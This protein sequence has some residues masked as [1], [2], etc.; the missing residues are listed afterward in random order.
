MD[1]HHKQSRGPRECRL[2]EHQFHPGHGAGNAWDWVTLIDNIRVGYTIPGPTNVLTAT[3]QSGAVFTAT[4]QTNGVTA[5]AAT[6]SVAFQTNSTAQSTGIV[7]SG[8]ANSSPAIVPG[9]YTVTAIYSG[10]GTYIGSTNTLVVG[11]NNFGPGV[12]KVNL[13]SGASTVVMSG[14]AGNN[15]SLQRATNITFTAGIS[16]FPTAMAPMGGNVTNVDNFSDL[17]RVPSAAFY[18]LHYI[19]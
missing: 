18:R 2:Y 13:T 12:G 8:I 16:N 1:G 6:G 17:G 15:Y 11:G 3:V 19:P 9:S 4:V 14:I 5:T 7:G 10:D